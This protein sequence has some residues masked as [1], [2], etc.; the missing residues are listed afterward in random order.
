MPQVSPVRPGDVIAGKYRVERVLGQGGMGYVVAARHLQLDQL[1]AIKLLACGR[2]ALDEGEATGRFVREAKA[3]GKLRNEHVARVFD[4][5]TLETGEPYMVMEHL[6]GVDLSKLA[7]QRGRIPAHEACEYVLQACE[8]LAEAHSFGFVHRDIKLA[9]L[10]VTTGPAGGPL[11]KV[12]DFG[13]SKTNPFGEQDHDI[14]R[15][16]S[17]LGSPRFMSPEQMR[18]PRAVDARSDV[19]SLGVV[20]YRL[21][22]GKPPFEADTLGRLLSMVMHEVPEPLGA[23]A[24]DLPPGFD[25]VVMRCLEKD[26]AR[27]VSS[28]AELAYALAPY[29]ADPMRGHAAADRIA[30]MLSV[31]PI[32]LSG[33][34]PAAIATGRP[35]APPHI[36]DTGGTAAPWTGTHSAAFGMTAPSRSAIV[37]AAVAMATLIV[38]AALFV[39][40]RHDQTIAEAKATAGETATANGGGAQAN[41]AL[42]TNEATATPTAMTPT[43]ATTAVPPATNAAPAPPPTAI[44]AAP[45]ATA[46]VAPPTAGAA[47][48]TTTTTS[49]TTKTGASDERPRRPGAGAAGPPPGPARPAARPSR[50]SS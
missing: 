33:S 34:F 43:T 47:T 7:K 6:E 27:R 2:H 9:N 46:I 39:K 20:L 23:V 31:A 16:S 32:A 29:A 13:I 5:G 17:M 3:A 45:P 41:D 14:T 19:W 50:S 35:S 37:W 40:V 48:T 26:P 1:V 36:A 8:A 15:S 28:V 25:A 22:G 10:F 24:P 4:V 11:V 42:G 18:D 12:L 21:C 44:V 30:A 49:T 38:A